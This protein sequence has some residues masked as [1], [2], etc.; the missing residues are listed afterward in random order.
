[1]VSTAPD[2]KVCSTCGIA[3]PLIEYRRRSRKSVARFGQC[4]AC[5]NAAERERRKV[6]TTDANRRQMGRFMNQLKSQSRDADV[7][8]VCQAMLAYFGG[9]KGFVEAWI[10]YYEEAR[11]E[12]SPQAIRCLQGMVRLIQCEAGAHPPTT[13]PSDDERRRKY[14]ELVK[15][16]IRDDSQLVATAALEIGWRLSKLRANSQ[17]HAVDLRVQT[18]AGY[19]YTD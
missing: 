3:K 14:G 7:H 6:K 8:R 2:H 15:A 10:E 1:M 4:R 17:L 16:L 9:L 19:S 12:R 13:Q 11:R 18:R 5:H